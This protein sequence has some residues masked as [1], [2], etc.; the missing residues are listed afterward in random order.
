[1]PWPSQSDASLLSDAKLGLHATAQQQ[2]RKATI[3]FM[4]GHNSENAT[5]QLRKQK[6]TAQGQKAMSQQS[7]RHAARASTQH[8]LNVHYINYHHVTIIIMFHLPFPPRF[9][10]PPGL[11]GQG[12]IHVTSIQQIT[13]RMMTLRKAA[14]LASSTRTN[15]AS[16]HVMSLIHALTR[17]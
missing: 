12:K 9:L 1:M 3:H 16:I 14:A 5:Q 6:A 8:S 15:S 2:L 10:D 13:V 7:S 4:K 11:R 17:G